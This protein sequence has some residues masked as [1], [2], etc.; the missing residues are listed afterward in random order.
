[1][2]FWDFGFWANLK[3]II[4]VVFTLIRSS[5]TS[6]KNKNKEEN[7]H[8]LTMAILS[9][10]GCGKNKIYKIMFQL[11]I[12]FKI[13]NVEWNFMLVSPFTTL[14]EKPSK[15]QLGLTKFIPK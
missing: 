7:A 12:F 1:M 6:N 2:G 5:N 9:G 8:M 4:N 14:L 11:S 3:K 13:C 10:L 15:T